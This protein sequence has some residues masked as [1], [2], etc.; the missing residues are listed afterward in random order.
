MQIEDHNPACR[1]GKP[2]EPLFYARVEEDGVMMARVSGDT[3]EHALAKATRLAEAIN[4]TRATAHLE[5]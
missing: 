5:Q 1:W 3:P 4:A 2:I